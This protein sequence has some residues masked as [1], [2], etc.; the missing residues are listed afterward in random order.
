MIPAALPADAE[1]VAV[2]G[3]DDEA[4]APVDRL[5]ALHA[6]RLETVSLLEAARADLARTRSEYEQAMTR[7]VLDG[8]GEPEAP[9]LGRLDAR[10]NGI[11]AALAQLDAD[12]AA[13]VSARE[14]AELDRIRAGAAKVCARRARIIALAKAY[15]RLGMCEILRAGAGDRVLQDFLATTR[16]GVLQELERSP[17]GAESF[18][19]QLLAL[20]DQARRYTH[21][22]G[23]PSAGR[24]VEVVSDEDLVP[25]LFNDE[26]DPSD[27]VRAS[28]S[29]QLGE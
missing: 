11:A 27:A 16:G 23:A 4:P 21:R 17:V 15:V 28:F 5:D 2:F 12:I 14:H 7:A 20:R 25:D 19:S 24:T 29:S 3:L 18:A 8:S 6:Q 26:S 22:L 1:P 9:D 13:E 10:C